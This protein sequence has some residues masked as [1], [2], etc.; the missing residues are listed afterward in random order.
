MQEQGKQVKPIDSLSNDELLILMRLKAMH[1]ALS[2]SK[3][4]WVS[5]VADLVDSIEQ[6]NKNPCDAASTIR[7]TWGRSPLCAFSLETRLIAIEP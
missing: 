5:L 4:A 2:Y 3:M 7:C 6:I 1:D